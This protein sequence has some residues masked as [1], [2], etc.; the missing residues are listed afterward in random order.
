MHRVLHKPQPYFHGYLGA[1]GESD[2]APLESGA[3]PN[4]TCCVPQPFPG[5]NQVPDEH[6][7]RM[8]QFHVHAANTQ[9]RQ[10][11]FGFIAALGLGRVLIMPKVSTGVKNA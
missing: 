7:E 8:V 1:G 9:L 5:F 4:P 2:R 11:Y 3:T 10:V 6:T